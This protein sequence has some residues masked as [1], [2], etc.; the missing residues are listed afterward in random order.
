M[1]ILEGSLH[2]NPFWLSVPSSMSRAGAIASDWLNR[3]SGL[4]DA[5]DVSQ[6]AY[7]SVVVM[8]WPI[9]IENDV[10]LTNL[11]QSLSKVEY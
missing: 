6:P 3:L 8:H 11:D 9:R 2:Q 4:Y 1:V 5:G 10:R 7:G